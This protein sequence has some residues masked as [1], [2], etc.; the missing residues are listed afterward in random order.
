MS[1]LEPRDLERM[2]YHQGQMLR[3]RDFHDLATN[4]SHLRWWHNR[5]LHQAYGVTKGFEPVL[6]DKFI[7]IHPGVAYDAY[8][9]ELVLTKQQRLELPEYD[10]PLVLLVR[11]AGAEDVCGQPPPAERCWPSHPTGTEGIEFVW[12]LEREATPYD[13]VRI[14]RLPTQTSAAIDNLPL[15][16][17]PLPPAFTFRRD[18]GVLDFRGVMRVEERDSWLAQSGDPQFSSVIKDLF[19]RSQPDYRRRYARSLSRPRVASGT[20]IPSNTPWTRWKLP[21]TQ[22]GRWTLLGYQVEIDTSAFG[23]TETPCYFAWLQGPVAELYC[24]SM[25]EQTLI[26]IDTHVD[27]VSTLGFTFRL[28]IRFQGG[29]GDYV[30]RVREGVGLASGPRDFYVSWIGIQPSMGA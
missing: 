19:R 28:M 2:R 4:E 24:M 13:G 26:E 6:D 10:E 16:F 11:Y 8:G 3:S 21:R 20:T 17:A 12:R 18:V 7:C 15:T 5:A 9:R 23:F 27:N 14:S 25:A 1:K 30:R 22:A 29:E